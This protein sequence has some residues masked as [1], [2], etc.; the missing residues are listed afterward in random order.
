MVTWPSDKL[1][2]ETW[3][4]CPDCG[5]RCDQ[6][7]RGRGVL[8]A[9]C[10]QHGSY[11]TSQR[12]TRAD[13]GTGSMNCE[14]RLWLIENAL[15]RF[16]V[17]PD[18]DDFMAVQSSTLPCNQLLFRFCEGHFVLEVGSREWD[19]PVC[20][21]RPLT[22]D[23]L[24]GLAELGFR[25]LPDGPNPAA[26][27]LPRDPRRL[28]L[29]ADDAMLCAYGED[30]DFEVGVFFKRTAVLRDVVVRLGHRAG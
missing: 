21:N 25:R 6:G 12:G 26:L 10:P 20:G 11:A 8:V 1:S 29:L 19:C 23:A 28:A 16:L 5:E 14:E 27:G 3:A 4:L 24:K 17:D 22:D 30:P 18:F 15:T 7:V 2:S 9:F 13:V